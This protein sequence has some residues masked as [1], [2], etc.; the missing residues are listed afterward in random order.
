MTAREFDAAALLDIPDVRNFRDAA[1]GV[2]RPGLLYRSAA[3]SGLTPEGA[4]R[5]KPLGIRT[6]IDLRTRAE[7]TAAP[8]RHHGLD[9]AYLHHPLLPERFD[10]EHPW[11]SDQ[12]ATYRLMAE[13]GG[14]AVAATV[15]RLAAGG[16][17]VLVHCAVGKDRTGLTIAVIQHLAGLPEADITADY[18][19]SNPGLGLD[20]GPVPYLDEYG[21][22]HISHPAEA[23]RLHTALDRI[24]ELHGSITDYLLAHGA[25]PEDLD[26]VRRLLTA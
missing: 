15:R 13:V 3:L 4:R 14:G 11:P 22:Q 8:D 10:R 5:L 12:F 21:E 20:R 17:P 6:V 1:C 24:R 9:H 2:L 18:L 23:D 16:G 26:T 7:S 25:T 19:R